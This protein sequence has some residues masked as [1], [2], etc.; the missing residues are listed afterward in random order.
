MCGYGLDST[1]AELRL[2][3]SFSKHDNGTLDSIKGLKFTIGRISVTSSRK[4]RL[5]NISQFPQT[6]EDIRSPPMCEQR[7]ELTGNIRSTRSTETC[8]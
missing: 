2:A 6:R 1:G 4:L 3:V 5:K 8:D 7:V